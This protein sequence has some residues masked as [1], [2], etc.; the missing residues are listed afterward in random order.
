MSA[1]A[2]PPEDAARDPNAPPA[3]SASSSSSSPA[4][5]STIALATFDPHTVIAP[6]GPV[7]RFAGS[8]SLVMARDI[9]RVRPLDTVEMLRYI[10]GLQLRED[11]AYGLRPHF[12]L[13][14]MDPNG[15]N[16]VA[17]LQ[18]GVPITLGPYGQP[19]VAYLPPIELLERIEVVRGTGSI[20]FGPQTVTGA[21]NFVT[22]GP[23]T[24]EVIRVRALGGLPL[25]LGA[26]GIYGN[27]IGN[28]SF[29]LGAVRRQGEGPR[30][31][32]FEITQVMGRFRLELGQRSDLTAR[33]DVFDQGAQV[34][35]VGLTAPM[36]ASGA[37]RSFALT[38][39]DW[40][41]LRRYAAALV[42][43]FR[44]ADN[45]RL[46][47][48]LHGTMYQ[49]STWE[50]QFDRAPVDALWYAR[51]QGD[52]S[53]PGGVLYFRDE[54]RST[55]DVYQVIGLE[56][57]LQA[58]FRLAGFRN[59]LDIGGR[60]QFERAELQR[61]HGNSQ[62]ARSGNVDSANVHEGFG[63]A[64]YLAD[65]LYL[66]EAWQVT[67][68]IRFESFSF[69]NL[70]RR[71]DGIDLYNRSQGSNVGLLPGGTIAFVQPTFTLFA[72]AHAGWMPTRFDQALESVR[73]ATPVVL[74]PERSVHTELG[75]RV[76]IADGLHIE[77]TG[78]WIER[79]Q[80]VV[81]GDRGGAPG[82][83]NRDA[84]RHLGAEALVQAD[85]GHLA[86]IAT[87]VY[88]NAQYQFVDAR[89]E[90]G[91]EDGHFIPYVS[92]HTVVAA[93]GVEHPIGF[94]AQV[95]WRFASDRFADIAN[96]PTESVDGR[97]GIL[98]AYYGLDAQ[99]SFTHRDTG[100][101]ITLGAKNI[102]GMQYISSRAT[103]GIHPG[104]DRQLFVTLRWDR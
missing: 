66:T 26:S 4:P 51:I 47:T 83:I 36:Y 89:L 35:S 39:N 94:G 42:H 37:Y 97:I 87:N 5:A 99:A 52:T 13:R 3:P 14:G 79:F 103:E 72:G 34:S 54:N 12:A 1:V 67:A 69:S 23:P 16:S 102:L 2:G 80:P 96:T 17:V 31:E 98:P 59:E 43:D 75:A 21:I 33:L 30:N 73:G 62:F 24:G 38:P 77:A 85:F 71:L 15:G 68:A 45:I 91:P 41:R 27:R 57:R 40:M 50:Q 88:V 10:P 28:A 82:W 46:R 76:Q 104:G 29:L 64:A 56:P 25:M 53:T 55:A 48:V 11:D 18:D 101:G 93:L 7:A 61:L 22:P 81:F 60:V 32:P 9:A 90:G 44:I 65:R 84:A 74:N 49:R 63:V 19:D 95:A 78:F 100:L 6:D 58:G 86:R 70:T 8:H 92:P 20:A